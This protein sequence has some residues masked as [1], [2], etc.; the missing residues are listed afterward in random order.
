[1]IRRVSA[2]LLLHIPHGHAKKDGVPVGRDNVVIDHQPV[3]HAVV[4]IQGQLRHRWGLGETEGGAHGEAVGGASLRHRLGVGA[5][6]AGVRL[7]LT[8]MTVVVYEHHPARV[9]VLVGGGGQRF[10]GLR[11]LHVETARSRSIVGIAIL[12][13]LN[14]GSDLSRTGN[15]I[16]VYGFTYWAPV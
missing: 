14:F 3:R 12:T 8:A 1:V 6:R 16:W 5:A 15:I 10:A 4:Q 9:V 7:R 11:S 2:V 13:G